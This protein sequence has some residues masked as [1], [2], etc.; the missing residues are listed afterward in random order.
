MSCLCQDRF[1]QTTADTVEEKPPVRGL[2]PRSSL[3]FWFVEWS[4]SVPRPLFGRCVDVASNG[5]RRNSKSRSATYT[6][7]Q[8]EGASPPLARSWQ[9]IVVGCGIGLPGRTGPCRKI[10]T[11]SNAALLPVRYIG[12]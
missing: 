12:R 4:A 5:E 2:L 10:L 8:R 3:T 7:N 11:R 6:A 9:S 1:K